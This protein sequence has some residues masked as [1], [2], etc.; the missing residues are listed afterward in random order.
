MFQVFAF[1]GALTF[2]LIIVKLEGQAVSRHQA[3]PVGVVKAKPY[4]V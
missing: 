1:I 4:Y 2:S 3:I